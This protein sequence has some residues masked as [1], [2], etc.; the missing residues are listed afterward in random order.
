VCYLVKRATQS[1][2][3]NT[4][5]GE[6]KN[7]GEVVEVLTTDNPPIMAEIKKGQHVKRIEYIKIRNGLEAQH[8]SQK[9][10]HRNG[11]QPFSY[12]RSLRNE[13]TSLQRAAG[14]ER[15]E[16]K[17]PIQTLVGYSFKRSIVRNYCR[18][19]DVAS[20]GGQYFAN[21]HSQALMKGLQSDH[22]TGGRA[23][24]SIKKGPY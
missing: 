14:V 21:C 12:T 1:D 13:S 16:K 8:S 4:K 17:E 9:G 11:S 2:P 22:P 3:K 5:R 19:R 23:T 15:K 24:P 7:I 18:K 6:G 20:N 10:A